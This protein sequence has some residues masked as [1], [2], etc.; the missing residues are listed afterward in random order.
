MIRG[1]FITASA[2]KLISGRSIHHAELVSS[3]GELSP[4]FEENALGSRLESPLATGR[5]GFPES[6]GTQFEA[7]LGGVSEHRYL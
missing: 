1:L 5:H 3:V 4:F 7:S 6:K 2:R